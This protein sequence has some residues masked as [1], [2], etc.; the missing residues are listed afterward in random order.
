MTRRQERL[1]GAV[2]RLPCGGKPGVVRSALRTC[3]SALLLYETEVR[4]PRRALAR[5]HG[6]PS[7][8]EGDRDLIPERRCSAAARGVGE[9]QRRRDPKEVRQEV[10]GGDLEAH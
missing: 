1:G 4:Q 2:A 3:G 10:E 7:E 6:G 8:A 9:V 5:R